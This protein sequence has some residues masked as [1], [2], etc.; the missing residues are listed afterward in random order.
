MIYVDLKGRMCN[1]M[2]QMA[3][4][5]ALALENNDNFKCSYNVSGIKPS[6]EQTK[7]YRMTIFKNIQFEVFKINKKN[8]DEGTHDFSYKEIDYKNG[9]CLSGYYQSEK[10]F[11]H[12]EK[13]IREMFRC[14]PKVLKF[15]EKKYCQL[16]HKNNTCAVHIRRGDYLKYKEFHNNLGLDYYRASFEQMKGKYFVFFSDDILWCKNNFKDL[17]GTFIDSKSDIIDFYLMSM[18]KNQIIANSSFSW[19]AAWLNTNKKKNVIA[20][21]KWFGNKNSDLITEDLLPLSWEVIDA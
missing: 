13:E 1:Q 4:A 5:K 6:L 20:P 10:Y 19:W 21:K 8:I 16:L 2:F 9:I 14:S 7:K 18:L 15:I 11:I 3:A 12:R 17:E